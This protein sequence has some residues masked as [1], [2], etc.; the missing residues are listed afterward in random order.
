MN[1]FVI[2]YF[3]HIRFIVGKF[4]GEE[5]SFTVFVSTDMESGHMRHTISR[6]TFF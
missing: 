5:I 6:A 4:I 1:G 3:L 2:F